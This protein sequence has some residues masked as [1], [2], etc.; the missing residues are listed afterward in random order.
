MASTHHQPAHRRRVKITPL[1]ILIALALGALVLG[2]SA[3]LIVRNWTP[4]RAT[5]PVQGITASAQ[6]GEIIWRTAAASGVDF[7]YLLASDGPRWRDPSFATNLA[8]A[9]DAGLRYGAVLRYNLCGPA[10]PQA[11]EF[12]AT[13]PRDDMML[14]PAIELDLRPECANRPGRDRLLADLNIMLNQIE[15]HAGKPA[16][17]RLS[18]AFEREYDLSSGINRTLWLSQPAFA[19]GYATRAWVMWT[20][21]TWKHVPGIEGAVEWNVVRP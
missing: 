21:S 15:A 12:I 8:G 14:P 18:S 19:P 16:M 10:T 3:W 11:T 2:G 6:S 1:R 17:L 9:R 5:Y 13:V 20:A 4:S 7:A